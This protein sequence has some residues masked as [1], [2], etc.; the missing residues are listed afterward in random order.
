MLIQQIDD[1]LAAY[2]AFRAYRRNGL[3]ARLT[4]YKGAELP[5]DLQ[6]WTFRLCKHNMQVP[7]SVTCS[8]YALPQVPSKVSASGRARCPLVDGIDDV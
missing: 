6:D 7:R 8:H 4:Y 1:H 5:K 2:E 3:D